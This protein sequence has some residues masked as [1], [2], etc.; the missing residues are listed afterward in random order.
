MNKLLI[1]L[2]LLGTTPLAAQAKLNIVTTATDYA[3]IAQQI[4]GDKVEVH[5][6]M[7]GPENVHN[8]MA[9]PTEMV[10]LN[11]ADLFVHGGLDSEPWRDNLLKG[12]RNPRVM[13]GKPGYVDMSNGIDLK[14]VPTGKIDRSMA[15][16]GGITGIFMVL[17]RES[18]LA[19]SVPQVVMLGAAVGLRLG[20][21]TLPP[22]LV[23]VAVALTLTAWCRRREAENLVLPALYIAGVCLSMLVI[24]NAGAHLMEV[25]N[26]FTGIDVAVG[27][28]QAIVISSILLST[29]VVCALFWRRWLLLAQAP[30]IAELARLRPVRWNALFLCLL[31]AVLV[32]ATHA[33][34]TVMVIGLLF[35]PAASVLPWT[36][37]IPNAVL[38]S[39]LVAVVAV[40]SG[41]VLSVEMGWPLSHSVGGAGFTVFLIS[42]TFAQLIR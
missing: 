16:A 23:T 40:A 38:A 18:L 22:A 35:L 10:F 27:E 15:I 2:C 36:R 11:Q 13:P 39:A 9:K 5:S 20:W 12:A 26:L 25:Q 32:L 33:L 8:V 7:K 28:R 30:A 17:R 19:L 31:A 21:P 14:E 41:F 34:G 4:G 1:A 6:V 29:G 42:H 24:A 37:R 3:D